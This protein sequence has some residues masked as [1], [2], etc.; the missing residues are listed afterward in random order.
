M[1]AAGGEAP[2]RIFPWEAVLD[3]GLCRL[4]LPP[5]VFWDLSLVEF[6]AMAGAFAPRSARLSRAGLVG[7]MRDY[8]D[9]GGGGSPPSV[10]A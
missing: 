2:A 1:R 9:D 3:A 7:L 4:R 5:S 10:T 8:P 6:A